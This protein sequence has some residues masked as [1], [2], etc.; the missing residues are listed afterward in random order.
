MFYESLVYLK[1]IVNQ[2]AMSMKVVRL[3][4]GLKQARMLFRICNTWTRKHTTLMLKVRRPD[5]NFHSAS[6]NFLL[7]KIH[8]KL[9]LGSFNFK[10]ADFSV[11]ITDGAVADSEDKG[12]CRQIE[13][14][15]LPGNM[16]LEQCAT[17]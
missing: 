6:K 17:Q 11:G 16:E 10:S 7:P 2:T 13:F 14:W 15:F 5:L 1:D 3:Y 8:V 4:S 9:H 12:G